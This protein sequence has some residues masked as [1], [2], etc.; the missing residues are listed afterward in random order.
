M[1]TGDEY[2]QSLGRLRH[3]VYYKG[4]RIENVVD[5]PITRP[6]INAAAVTY[7]LAF[8]PLHE[9]LASATS[10]LTG[11]RIN[12]WTHIPHSTDDLVKKVKMLR[13]AAQRTGTCFQRCVGMDALIALYGVTFEM[14][15]A[16]GTDY[17]RRLADFVRYV[18]ANDW[19]SDGAMTDPKGDR[20]LPPER[21][22]DPDLYL[23]VVEKRKDGIIVRGA[24]MHQTGAI[25]SHEIIAMPGTALSPE[26]EA[27]AVAFA[28]PS[29]TNGLAYIFGR[30]TNDSRRLEGEIDQGNASYGIVGGEALVVFD[31]V[32]V[33]WERVFMCG[34]HDFAGLLVDRF[35]RYHRQNY[36]GCKTGNLDVL[37]GATLAVAEYLGTARSSHVRDKI[38]E[39]LHLTETLY[40]CSIACSSQGY[41][42]PCGA[43][44]VDPLLANV[45]KLNTTRFYYEACRLAH[46][47]AGGF[48]ATLPSEQDLRSSEIGEYVR[49][50][51]RGVADVPTEH[52][53]RI[54]R[55]IENMSSGVALVECMHGAG[56][57]EAQKIGIFRHGNLENKRGLALRLSGI[58]EGSGSRTGS[59]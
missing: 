11:Q 18:Q 51:L 2:I 56:S 41:R 24:K 31:D 20:R 59:V 49:K 27:Y 5:S 23:R 3:T 15:Q 55:L 8:D 53:I 57:P 22:A 25:N 40:A 17:H 47:I 32:L 36:G 10:H 19:M 35:A 48:I 9:D 4:K 12:R 42:L 34:E 13:M 29:D 54:G 43:Y 30:Q 58:S 1:M 37:T 33:P 38:S 39:M 7:D 26:A 50:Y 52:R 6:H 16:R 28:I 14:D 46:D 21:Q 44:F 45:A